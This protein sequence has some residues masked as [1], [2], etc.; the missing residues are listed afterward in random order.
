M[1]NRV[2]YVLLCYQSYEKTIQE[3]QEHL[4]DLDKKI[5]A[6]NKANQKMDAKVAELT[7]D[8]NEQQLLRNLEFA[9]RQTDVKQR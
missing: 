6:Q 3:I 5:S 7:V 1:I 8:V 4:D 9:S 2:L